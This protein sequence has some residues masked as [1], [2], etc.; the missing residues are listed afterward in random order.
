MRTTHDLTRRMTLGGFTAIAAV[1]SCGGHARAA[2]AFRIGAPNPITGAAGA[3]GPG[4]QKTLIEAAVRI[5]A[6]GGAGGHQLEIVTAD[7]QSL[8]EPALLAARKLVEVDKVRALLGVYSSPET[9][10]IMPMSNAAGVIVMDNGAAPRIADENTKGLEYQFYPNSVSIGAMFTQVMAHEGF[11]RPVLL[12]LSNDAEIGNAVAFDTQWKKTAGTSAPEVRYLP[13][14]ASYMSELQKVLSTNPDVIILNAYEPDATIVLK[15]LYELGNSAEIISGDFAVT[16]RLVAA[17]GHD[18]VEGTLVYRFAP[19]TGSP[20]YREFDAIYQA[21]MKQPGSANSFAAIAFDQ[22]TLV[23][24][25]LE[26]NPTSA[27]GEDLTRAIHDVCG[28]DGPVVNTFAEG[29]EALKGGAAKLN[30]E[31][32]SGPCDFDA[33]GGTPA[34]FG[35]SIVKDG[36]Y[37]PQYEIRYKR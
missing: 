26:K 19:T 10:A 23:A 11:K 20:A 17:V 14:Q 18:V 35:I 15:Q 29:R 25:A 6:A 8:P 32:A 7:S 24:L 5:N 1:A 16:P 12:T 34:D 21:T 37:V 22:I 13:G 27:T 33:R 31:G 2:E 3:F 28:P 4:M 36:K 30:Y 9:L